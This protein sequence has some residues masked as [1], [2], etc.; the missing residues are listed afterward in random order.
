MAKKISRQEEIELI[1]KAQAGDENATNF[2]IKQYGPLAHRMLPYQ[3]RQDEDAKADVTIELWK[4]I[5]KFDKSRE[6]RFST[7]LN[8]FV[9]DYVKVTHRNKNAQKRYGEVCSLDATFPDSDTSLL[10]LTSEE[11]LFIN[12][13]SHVEQPETAV[14]ELSDRKYLYNLVSR[15]EMSEDKAR[16]LYLHLQGKSNQEISEILGISSMN[17]AMTLNYAKRKL[18]ERHIL[19]KQAGDFLNGRIIS[20]F[21][22]LKG[23]ERLKNQRVIFQQI[24]EREKISPVN[25]SWNTLCEYRLFPENYRLNRPTKAQAINRL[26]PPKKR[27]PEIFFPASPRWNGNKNRQEA[28]NSLE[29][30]ILKDMYTFGIPDYNRVPWL[31]PLLTGLFNERPNEANLT[32]QKERFGL[33]TNQRVKINILSEITDNNSSLFGGSYTSAMEKLEGHF[34]ILDN[35]ISK[36]NFIERESKIFDLFLHGKTVREISE[37]LKKEIDSKKWLSNAVQQNIWRIKNKI[38]VSA[39]REYRPSFEEGANL[40]DIEKNISPKNRAKNLHNRYFRLNLSYLINQLAKDKNCSLE[41]LPYNITFHNNSVGELLSVSRIFDGSFFNMFDFAIPG[42]F[43]DWQ[44]R[45]RAKWDGEEGMKRGLD[46]VDFILS[47]EERLL[48]T[49]TL[50]KKYH[51]SAM[52][53]ELFGADNY[54]AV[55]NFFV[56]NYLKDRISIKDFDKYL[57][58]RKLLTILF[59]TNGN[60]GLKNPHQLTGQIERIDRQKLYEDAG[61][62]GDQI[63]EWEYRINSWN[64]RVNYFSNAEIT[65]VMK[66]TRVSVE[67]NFKATRDKLARVVYAK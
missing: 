23:T 61:L 44:F 52:V 34:K 6:T 12:T 10:E 8:K 66:K 48:F 46:A 50:C 28:L 26:L 57:K 59:E 67:N 30:L 65:R 60:L 39:I 42:L 7:I 27:L 62:T 43:R 2:L 29:D 47:K 24:L 18:E 53:S 37:I 9:N 51:L 17:C 35:L 32:I 45:Y 56:E 22:K 13:V 38:R 58:N 41:D 33:D 15:T 5:K 55:N 19:E 20:P 31:K 16:V 1:E 3:L 11:D 49:K 40:E 63:K 54:S 14:S 21:K 36:T 25:V 4:A 64:Y